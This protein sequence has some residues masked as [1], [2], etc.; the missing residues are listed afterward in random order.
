MSPEHMYWR[1][2]DL[3]RH[4]IVNNRMT[5]WR[6]I[7][8]QGF[9]EGVLL[10]P[11]SRAWLVQEVHSWLENRKTWNSDALRQDNNFNVPPGS[12]GEKI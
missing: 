2:N 7:K 6:W 10:G 12:K 3:K 4:G 9:P 11:N 1:F 8:D 5:L